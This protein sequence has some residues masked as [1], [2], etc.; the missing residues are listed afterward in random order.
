MTLLFRL[1]QCFNIILFLRRTSQDSFNLVRKCH[2]EYSSEMHWLRG[3]F[4]KEIFWSQTLKNWKNMNASEIHARRLNA[5]ETI[6][7]KSGEPFYIPNSGWNSKNVWKRSW[8]PRAH[9]ETGIHRKDRESLRIMAMVKSL[10]LKNQKMTQKLGKTFGLFKEISFIVIML[11][12]V[13]NSTCRE[14]NQSLFH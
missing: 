8:S 3:E 10:N 12:R 9:S 6:T 5:K 2:L 4:G 14:K 1:V 13:F 7:P 11:N